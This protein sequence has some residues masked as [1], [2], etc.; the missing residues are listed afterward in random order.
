MSSLHAEKFK[1]VAF[2]SF[3]IPSV[4]GFYR[5]LIQKALDRGSNYTIH[6]IYA[7]LLSGDMQLWAWDKDA[8]LVTSIQNRDDKRWCLF[9]A[10]GGE[11]MDEWK[12]HLP[13]VEDWARSN[14]CEEMRI[15]GR[16]GWAK[17]GFDIVYTKMVRKL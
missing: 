3:H 1:L 9:I 7:G 13:I 6:D 14:G 16:R 5:P 8:A 12:E 17:L 10:L 4:W 2:D 11:N 15:Y